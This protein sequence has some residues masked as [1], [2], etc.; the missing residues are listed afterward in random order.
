MLPYMGWMRSWMAIGSAVGLAIIVLL[1]W[2][3]ARGSDEWPGRSD[4]SLEQI[5][6]RRYARGEI[7]GDEQEQ[8]LSNVKK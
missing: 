3:F 4:E 6:K 8:R 7:D 2:A 5:L 1:A